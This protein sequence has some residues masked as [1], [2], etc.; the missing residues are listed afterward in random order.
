MYSAPELAALIGVLRKNLSKAAKSALENGRETITT[1]GQV[2]Y[3]RRNGRNYEF[4]ATPFKEAHAGAW[5]SLSG[6]DSVPTPQRLPFADS[7]SQ[8]LFNALSDKEK[9]I[10]DFKIH[11]AKQWMHNERKGA[12][13]LSAE[14][15][16]EEISSH[17]DVELSSA[18]L[19]IRREYLY[20]WS[21][22]LKN[23]GEAGFVKKKG[24]KEGG[25]SVPGWV[26]DRIHQ[27]F[28]GKSGGITNQNIYEIVNL[29]ARN[30]GELSDTMYAK[31]RRRKNA[32]GIIS[33]RR[34][35]EITLKLRSTRTYMMVKNPDAF[36][37]KTLP[38]FGDMREKAEYA[39]HYWEIDSTK[40]DAF[41]KDESGESTWSIIAISD[42]KSAMKVVSIVKNSNAQ[43]IAELL[44]KA[45]NKIGIPEHIITDNGKDY[46]SNHFIGIMKMMGIKHKKTAPYSGEQKP[47]AERHFGTLQNS[48]TELLNGFK[49]HSVSQMQAIN[50][51]TSTPERLSGR[52]PDKDVEHISEI[53]AKLDS[54]VENVYAHKYNRGL[55][56]TPYEAYVEDEHMITRRDMKSIAYTFGKRHERV[57]GKKG[58]A[59]G[60]QI[61]NNNDGMLGDRV[62][63]NV[64][65]SIDMHNDNIGYIFDAETEQFIC[66]VTTDKITQE[67]AKAARVIHKSEVKRHEALV[68]TAVKSQKGRD[69]IHELNQ[70][71]AEVF[72]NLT[73]VEEVGG[74]GFTQNAGNLD[75]LVEQGQR[76]NEELD[77][78]NLL[79]EGPNLEI[80]EALVKAHEEQRPAVRKLITPYSIIEDELAELYGES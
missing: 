7:E 18:E 57:V 41:G 65:I 78:L 26:I 50:A 76:I 66:I 58:I 52:V 25:H 40:L 80:A 5:V 39:N 23:E 11:I 63:G 9:K 55:D 15:F 48:F 34:I 31:T 8:A 54:W 44:Y 71:G 46:L 29:E 68:R 43:G 64:L 21:D 62:S 42:V 59:I 49:G 47:F 37:N 56:R 33:L 30:R 77:R 38:G 35:Q 45:F 27:L 36:K 53:A 6:D 74:N 17:F 28:W 75:Y 69:Y 24:R 67:G 70:A 32:G 79:S 19:V 3:V 12:Y 22:I 51:R 16:I 13:R 73:P 2:Y 60:G 1:K 20:R 72:G 61:Y 10:V 4:S 14:R